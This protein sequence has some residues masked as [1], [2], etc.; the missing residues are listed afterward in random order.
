MAEK[1][2]KEGKRASEEIPRA[3]PVKKPAKA[4][5]A[6]EEEEEEI[7]KPIKP[8]TAEELEKEFKEHSV[9][10][11]FKKNR[12]MLGLVGKIRCL[13]TIVH[14]YT[15]N[16]LDAAEESG[17][18]PDVDVTITELG[19]EH[20]EV[21]VVDNGPGLTQES[22]G[23]AFGQLL[24]GTKFHRLMQMRGQQGIG[25]CMKSDTLVP[26]AD[27]RVMTI[28]EIVDNNMVGNEIISLDLKSMKLVP[29]KII[30]CWKPK[31]PLFVKIKTIKGREIRLTPENP[32]LIINEGKPV[33]I[34]ADEVIEG[35]KIAAPNK[36][37]AFTKNRPTI[38]LFDENTIQ[39]DNL[40][41][42]KEIMQELSGKFKS[43]AG[44]AR[45]LGVH[46]DVLRNWVARKMPNN[47]PRGR[48]IL[49][50]LLKFAGL[51]GMQRE[52]IIPKINRVGRM[53]TF[54]NIPLNIDTETA[55]V[56]GLIAG[57][58]HMSSAKDDKWGVNIIFT[59]K[60]IELIRKYKEI[61][62]NKF[63]LKTQ[64]YFHEGKKYYTVQ[65][66]SKILSE[67][68]EFFG[69]PRGNKTRTLDLSNNLFSL[70]ED[71][72]ASYLRGLFDAEGSVS[73]EKRTV[74]LLLYNKGFLEKVFY[75]LLRFGIHANIN[76]CGSEKRITITEKNNLYAF[77]QRIGFAAARKNS[78]LIE[79]LQNKK[80]NAQTDTIQGINPSVVKY[81]QEVKM[82]ISHLP[83]APYSAL[84]NQNIS[85][86]S[87]RQLLQTT[88][89]KGG[90]GKFLNVLAEADVSWL[91]V[92]EVEFEK[93]EEGFVYDLEIE[94]HHNFV[95]GGIV[96][97]NSGCTV[98]AQMTTGKP[99][100]VIT[101]SGKGKP[102]AVDVAIDTK[103]NQPKLSN[104]E[105]LQ[106]DFK[107][108]A[109]RAE[110][111]GV[112][113]RQAEQNAYEYLRRTAVANPHAKISFKDPTGK[114]IIFKRTVS[115]LPE[116]PKEIKPH[117]KGATVDEL[118][119]LS[120]YTEARKISSFLK[121]EFERFGDK[122]LEE[123]ANK[124]HFDLNKDPKKLVWAEAEE[125]INAIKA[126]TFLAPSTE[127]LRPIG[128]DRIRKSLLSIVKPEFLSVITRKPQVYAEG[129]PFQVE[130]G[131]AYGGEAGRANQ[132]GN[133]EGQQARSVEIMRFANR[134]PLL[135]DSGGCA[136]TKAVQTIE[137]KR[138]GVKDLENVPL[139]VF[140][141]LISVHVPYTS[142]G[143]Q[144]IAEEEEIIEEIRLALM[145][146]G[147][148]TARYIANKQKE[149]DKKIRRETFYKYIPEIAAALHNIT[150]EDEKKL[151]EKLEKLV[152]EKLKI[153]EKQEAEEA[154][155]DVEAL[156]IEEVENESE[157]EGE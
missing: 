107:G 16:S 105:M 14:E 146:T 58:G 12:Q 73:K 100:K 131:I 27:G 40:E 47:A 26:L 67:I 124:I 13:T 136:I 88:G 130:V 63:G 117:P 112:L 121:S 1:K 122:A 2:E 72:I 114:K 94:T 104:I 32:V 145:D 125:I 152:T 15:T 140:V 83:I 119:S 142:A 70:N 36:L 151:R 128:E 80:T 6:S 157:S 68:M 86:N 60:D 3:Q 25:A 139:T 99:V 54:T 23:K 43:R 20:Y 155:E 129:F 134:A 61:I 154:K 35:M 66:S 30:K 126:I 28:K 38:E 141:N 71:I 39:V 138:Y 106:K 108:T 95:A 53:G 17:I 57:D 111:K 147:R 48:P 41:L 78:L 29:G 82:P 132:N 8:L 81:L 148:K 76:K 37:S 110:F 153:I 116:R 135:F 98:F 75:A 90:D 4:P 101:G 9:A 56:A 51:A 33:W 7:T 103:T 109:V 137:W 18:L 143:K 120:K 42:L 91:E 113:Y 144:A 87:L 10:E 24:A 52:E 22:V 19:P 84:Y 21:T 49:K 92:M 102:F 77:Y 44:I 156:Q 62:E 115:E 89:V 34:R 74:S 50:Q 55:W 97:H 45:E 11:F 149:Y 118:L 64:Q 123:V 46:K 150:K 65:C 96:C 85:R 79:L 5:V 31:N 93:N 127:G 59:N 133:G 69:V